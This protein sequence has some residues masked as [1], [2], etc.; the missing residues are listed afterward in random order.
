VKAADIDEDGYI[1]MRELLGMILPPLVEAEA[2]VDSGKGTIQRLHESSKVDFRELVHAGTCTLEDYED[3]NDGVSECSTL[4]SQCEGTSSNFLEFSD[5]EFVCIQ[6]A[7]ELMDADSD[8]RLS[9]Q[10]LRI[11]LAGVV[12]DAKLADW[13]QK[14]DADGDGLISY[15]EF[16]ELI[17]STL[18]E[19]I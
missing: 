1:N 12:D 10:E 11:V 4:P 13:F 3:F 2:K 19:C 5:A 6:K 15:V 14:A 18:P 16:V 17:E 9:W 7:F 8:G